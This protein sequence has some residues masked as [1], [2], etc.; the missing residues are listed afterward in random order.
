MLGWEN[1][2]ALKTMAVNTSL[3]KQISGLFGIWHSVLTCVT[4]ALFKKGRENKEQR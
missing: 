4:I 1:Y 3:S 2:L